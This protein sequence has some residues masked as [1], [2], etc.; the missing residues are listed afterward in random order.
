MDDN[1]RIQW[2]TIPHLL[3][4]TSRRTH[5][6]F[7]IPPILFVRISSDSLR[8]DNNR[9]RIHSSLGHNNSVELERYHASSSQCVHDIFLLQL[10]IVCA[11]D[12]VSFTSVNG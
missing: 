10:K 12:L 9:C 4:E 5:L 6:F 3:D 2:T 8:L 7:I 1:F 11:V